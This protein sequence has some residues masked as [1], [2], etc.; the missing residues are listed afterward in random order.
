MSEWRDI[1][2]KELCE[3]IV[4]CVNKTA[5]TTSADTPYKMIR[6]TNVRDGWIET[7][8][9]R[10]VDEVTYRKWT[11]RAV[12]Q[13]EDIILTREAPLGEVGLL[14]TDESVFLGQR[15]MMYRADRRKS[16]PR[17]LLYAL[18]GESVQAQLRSF[19]S[20]ATVEH[21]RVPD[22]ERLI[23]RAPDVDAQR[24]IGGFLGTV[25]NLIENSR[26]RIGL[27][28]RMTQAIYREWF[29]NFRYPG[30]ENDKFV[31]SSL[32]SIPV[33][34][35]IVSADEAV[36][37]NPTVKA[38][39]R[40]EVPFVS[41]SDLSD[42]LMI[43]TPSSTREF[44]GGGSRFEQWDTLLARITPSIEHGKTGFVQFLAN[45][46]AGKG[47]TEFIIMRQEVAIAIFNISTSPPR[48]FSTAC[49]WEHDRRLRQ[50]AC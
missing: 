32:G 33:G 18:M 38:P 47:S 12:P 31:D 21:V 44:A 4:D 2:I 45:G 16:D 22:C 39:S 29:V 20:G 7:E 43:V 28:E 30:Y 10:H 24:S 25:D 26:W 23:I 8:N 14:R 40:A 36:E 42:H 11:R 3:L 49:Y 5:P 48:R 34:W 19:G 37:I 1:A 46:C 35:D 9:V 50:T 17:F 27:L 6:T 13:R 15:L 41:M